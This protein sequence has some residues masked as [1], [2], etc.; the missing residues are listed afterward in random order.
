MDFLEGK[1]VFIDPNVPV[2][3][4]ESMYMRLNHLSLLYNCMLHL[5]VL[6]VAIKHI[7]AIVHVFGVLKHRVIIV[8]TAINF[9]NVFKGHV[10]FTQT[11]YK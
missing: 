2:N 9:L 5:D 4:A 8:K 11:K 1:A 10:Y 6:L 3:F 7:N